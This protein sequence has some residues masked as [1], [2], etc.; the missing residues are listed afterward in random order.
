MSGY[1][2]WIWGPGING[3]TNSVKRLGPSFGR[4]I[5]R[6]TSRSPPW[7][8]PPQLEFFFCTVLSVRDPRGVFHHLAS[9]YWNQRWRA[10]FKPLIFGIAPTFQIMP[11]AAGTGA[12][13]GSV[14]QGAPTDPRFTGVLT[15]PQSQSCNDVFR[16]ASAA[17][18]VASS[19][20][21]HESPV[22]ASFDVRRS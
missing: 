7:R 14:I 5:C 15:S 10:A 12:S 18:A 20:N 19:F 22:W 21:R 6:A 17:V 2:I 3:T 11:I 4:Q 9:F 1:S 16:A 13:V 8:A